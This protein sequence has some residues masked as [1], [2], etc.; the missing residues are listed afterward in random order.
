MKESVD[1]VV[2]HSSPKHTEVGVVKSIL[3]PEG[4][5][6]LTSKVTETSPVWG[7]DMAIE[8]GACSPLSST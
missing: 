7:V 6:G 8:G 4:L 1:D 2:A 3:S 5:H